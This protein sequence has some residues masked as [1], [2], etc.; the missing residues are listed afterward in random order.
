MRG[1]A[2]DEGE[3]DGVTF[4]PFVSAFNLKSVVIVREIDTDVPVLICPGENPV[5]LALKSAN[6]GSVDFFANASGGKDE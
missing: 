3:R 4:G 6:A 2:G 1:S 5:A